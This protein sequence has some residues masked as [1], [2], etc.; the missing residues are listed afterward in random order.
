MELPHEY[1]RQHTLFDIASAIVTPLS[2]DESTS[3][4]MFGCYVR[5]LVDMG[6]YH[7]VFDEIMVEMDEFVFLLLVVYKHLP[8]FCSNCKVIGHNIAACK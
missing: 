7:R 1:W 5:H 8:Y 4:H 3:N 2:L 6:I